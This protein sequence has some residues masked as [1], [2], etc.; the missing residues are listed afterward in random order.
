MQQQLRKELQGSWPR[1]KWRPTKTELKTELWT[2]VVGQVFVNSCTSLSTCVC[3]NLTCHCEL[4]CMMTFCQLLCIPSRVVSMS[5]STSWASGGAGILSKTFV[6][7]HIK[8]CCNLGKR[9]T[10]LSR[11]GSLNRCCWTT[12]A[13]FVRALRSSSTIYFL[14]GQGPQAALLCWS[15]S[16]SAKIFILLILM[17]AE[18]NNI[19]RYDSIIYMQSP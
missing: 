16:T 4:S 15:I 19:C 17:H 2:Y 10:S 9:L 5:W 1:G 14:R 8:G 12:E 6:F 18:Y 13:E 3:M 7:V 11:F